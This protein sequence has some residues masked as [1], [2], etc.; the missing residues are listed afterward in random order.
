[1]GVTVKAGTDF[2]PA[3][4]GL[5]QAVCV[6]VVDKGMVESTFNG[7]KSTRHRIQVRWQTEAINEKQGARFLVISTFTASLHKKSTLRGFL[8]AWRGRRFTEEELAGF[9]LDQLLGVNCQLNIIHNNVDGTVYANVASIM[10]LGKGMSKLEPE[11]YVRVQDRP[12]ES[13]PPRDT[14]FDPPGDGEDDIPF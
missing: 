5:H 9:D 12:D 10:P 7:S 8:E 14:D 3:P 4:E 1:M 6:D 13:R 11:Q 2:V